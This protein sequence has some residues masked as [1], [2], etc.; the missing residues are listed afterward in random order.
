MLIKITACLLLFS[1]SGSLALA[2]SPQT[3]YSIAVNEI[4]ENIAG[5]VSFQFWQYDGNK[6][7]KRHIIP[8]SEKAGSYAG[9]LKIE[10]SLWECK[11]TEGRVSADGGVGMK[12]AFGIKA[13]TLA[14]S[15][16]AVV[17]NFNKWSRNNYVFIP[18]AVYDG[19]RFHVVNNGYLAPYP[20]SYYYNKDEPLLFSNSPRLSYE[21]GKASKIEL[22]T[23]NASTPAM[24]FYSPAL[25]RGFILLTQQGTRFGNSGLFIKENASQD[26]A[27]FIVTAPSVRERVAGFGSFGKS[28][29]KG[30]FW[31]AGDKVTLQ[32]RLYSFPATGIPALLKKFMTVRKVLTGPNHPR[33]LTPFSAVM[34]F[35]ARHEDA[36]RWY[37]DPTG[38]FYRSDN[39]N[40]FQLGWVGG[41]QVT[42]P[43][44]ALDD[45]LHRERVFKNIDLVV[46]RMQGK[47]GYFWGTYDQG[48]LI[49]GRDNIPYAAM[50]RKNADALFWM[51]KQFL[52]L[53][54]QGHGNL[55]EP[56][57]EL[58][59]SRLAQAFTKTWNDNG[60]FGQYV[61][62]KTG[63]IIIFNST[64][65]AIAP[66]GLVLA[67]LYFHKPEFIRVAK[68]AAADYYNQYVLRL[69][70]T[71]GCCGDI[72]QDADS[73][74]AF[75]LLESMMALY[76]ATDD[77][78]WLSKA[79]TVADLCATWVL[80]YDEKFPPGSTLS[81]L[82]A[83]VAGAV[84]ASVQNKH[85]APG[86]ATSSAD[87]L[88]KLY[89][90]TSDRHYADLLNDITHAH[91]EVMETPG[92]PTTG[93]GAGTSMER[94]QPTDA[95][96]KGAIGMILH[97]SNTWTETN[98]MLMALEIP[99]IYIQT[100]KDEMYVFDAVK[101]KIIRRGAAGMTLRITNPTKFNAKVSIFAESSEQAKVPIGYTTF[102][103][104]PKV[105]IS[106]DKSCTIHINPEGGIV[107]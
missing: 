12:A 99:G 51:T 9:S 60:Q 24:C 70:L 88:F 54:F 4:L 81:D 61:N 47:S 96:G 82:H 40:K 16:V 34:K 37:E 87:Y 67:G 23:G 83:H 49:N 91:A 95:D 107:R 78:E 66:A 2:Q 97:T 17:F 92:R 30:A 33:D 48:K 77:T 57:W 19:N 101:V 93:M 76:Y 38:S 46:N 59:L 105:A 10:N 20:R 22:L 45:S 13:G 3:G 15:G 5:T 27:S 71:G 56:K 39:D 74:T 86:V 31:K 100:D 94:I 84:F 80:S 79:K 14:S 1:S 53:K 90:A 73:E 35:T 52:L 8:V 55:I 98:G 25:Q 64:A 42:F 43:L 72:L 102:L 89:R 85:A 44:L 26:S 68:A 28:N 11:L 65:G 63:R 50:V 18:A 62:V 69:G 103:K 106:A 29:D 58:A 7:T 104:W 6:V 36:A 32:F 21:G 75:G 41:L